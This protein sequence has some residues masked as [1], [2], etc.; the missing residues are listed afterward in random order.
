MLNFKSRNVTSLL[1]KAFNAASKFPDVERNALAR[2]LVDEIESDREWDSIF[3]AS[4]DFLGQMV[5]DALSEEE[6]KKSKYEYC[7][8]YWKWLRY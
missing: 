2:W 7:I 1:E 5:F 6:Q 3:S 8:S 4:E